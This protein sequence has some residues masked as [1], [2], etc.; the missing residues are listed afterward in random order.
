MRPEWKFI[1]LLETGEAEEVGNA[2]GSTTNNGSPYPPRVVVIRVV[3][4]AIRGQRFW[5]HICH[6]VRFFHIQSGVH[7]EARSGGAAGGRD[8]HEADVAIAR[9]GCSGLVLLAVGVVIVALVGLAIEGVGVSYATG[10]Y[11]S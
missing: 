4:L 2:L 8:F 7:E 6:T 9:V 1:L 10:A 11:S 5:S 3:H